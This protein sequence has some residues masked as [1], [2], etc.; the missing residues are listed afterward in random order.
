MKALLV[1]GV[2]TIS[3]GQGLIP[4]TELYELYMATPLAPPGDA[5]QDLNCTFSW[6]CQVYSM[7]Q[8]IQ[9]VM[10]ILAGVRI[11]SITVCLPRI[12]AVFATL[13]SV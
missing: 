6:D 7:C 4:D 12:L 10:V 8:G 9:V 2:V 1:L 5:T 3:Q 13:G 11:T